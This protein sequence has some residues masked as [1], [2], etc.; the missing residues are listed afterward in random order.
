MAA[1]VFIYIHDGATNTPQVS[2]Y[3]WRHRKHA[4][5][6][7]IFMKQ[8]KKITCQIERG[9]IFKHTHTHAHIEEGIKINSS[10][11][12]CVVQCFTSSLLIWCVSWFAHMEIFLHNNF[13]FHHFKWRVSSWSKFLIK[14]KTKFRFN[15]ENN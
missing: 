13:Y 10:Y 11:H 12:P 2:T 3:A 7:C 9:Y 8:K 4:I 1:F 6:A 15:K 14:N 5:K